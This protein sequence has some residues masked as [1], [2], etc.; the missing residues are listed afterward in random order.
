[1]P[2]RQQRQTTSTRSRRH[3]LLAIG[4][5]DGDSTVAEREQIAARHLDA[6]AIGLRSGETP[7]GHATI[8]GDEMRGVRPMGIRKRSEH[9]GVGRT[10]GLPTFAPLSVKVSPADA[11]NMQSSA[12]ID[13]SA[14]R[15][16]RF[17]AS[18]KRSSKL[19]NSAPE[20]AMNS[21]VA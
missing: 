5:L 1:V 2:V 9:G 17:H 4:I 21:M 11:W 8:A 10:N 3:S 15:S 12:I 19:S 18:A 14:S 20:G 6:R 16:C 7:L 13:I